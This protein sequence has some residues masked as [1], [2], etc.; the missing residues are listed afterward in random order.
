MTDTLFGWAVIASI[1]TH[2]AGLAAAAALALGHGGTPPPP[3]RV[4]IEVVN[5]LE[6]KPAPP[7]PPKPERRPALKPTRRV[8]T[9]EP[10]HARAE[11]LARASSSAPAIWRCVPAGAW[12]AEAVPA[13]AR[14]QASRR[15]GQAMRRARA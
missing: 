14:A 6:E 10:A 4:P 15:P 5:V 8:E 9:R 11:P 12:A 3:I 1:G 7:P 2:V 13:G